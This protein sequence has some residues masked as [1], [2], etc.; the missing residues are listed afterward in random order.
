[1]FL[2][3][4]QL[5]RLKVKWVMYLPLYSSSC[6]NVQC[7]NQAPRSWLLENKRPEY[8]DYRVTYDMTAT[9]SNSETTVRLPKC[10]A[11]PHLGE[12]EDTDR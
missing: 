11:V 8:S 5:T 12:R 3:K 7:I 10:I 9:Y 2:F 6:E 1:M 4:A